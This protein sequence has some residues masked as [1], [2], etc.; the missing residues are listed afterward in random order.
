MYSVKYSEVVSVVSAVRRPG[1][2][3]PDRLQRDGTYYLPCKIFLVDNRLFQIPF[4]YLSNESEIFRGMADVPLPS[5]G[6]AEGMSDDHP[7]RLEG[8]SK[9]DFRQLLR[10]LCPPK[11][12]GREE[13]LSFKQWISV[14][15]LADLWCM[16]AVRAHA[17]EKMSDMDADPVEKVVV[18]R[19]YKVHDW[20]VPA[21]NAIIS[22][23][24]TLSE[25]DVERLGVSTILRLV[26]IRDRLQRDYRNYVTLS[27][28]RQPV[29]FDFT[30]AIL[31][32]IPEC[33]RGV[34]VLSI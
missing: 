28:T 29:A 25:V 22:R 30:N 24:Q 26:A 16:D 13:V 33:R 8:V 4:A 7:I 9:E 31:A 27:A 15:K 2:P 10:V 18:A 20:L 11:A 12:S 1:T 6:T 17:I 32:E 14:L 21:F 19:Q 5:D 34:D 3:D 23:S